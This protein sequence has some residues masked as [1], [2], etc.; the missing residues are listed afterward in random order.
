MQTLFNHQK[1]PTVP[2]T[3]HGTINQIAKSMFHAFFMAY[4]T[5]KEFY[6][7]TEDTTFGDF[8]D[9]VIVTADATVTAI[10]YKHTK[11]T[12]SS[13][14]GISDITT[15]SEEGK[16]L[17]FYKYYNSLEINRPDWILQ[18]GLELELASNLS[19][20]YQLSICI[21]VNSTHFTNAFFENNL[22]SFA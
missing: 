22:G 1:R 15:S 17:T 5:N 12:S 6:I 7:V 16:K 14:I 11:I 10:Q 2:G 3:L 21:D 9:L 20:E 13:S 8:D 19:V 4:K 18:H